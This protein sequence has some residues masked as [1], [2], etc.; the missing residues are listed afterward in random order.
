MRK[1]WNGGHSQR[2]LSVPL[3][4][5]NI[6][7]QTCFP[8]LR[9]ISTS[10]LVSNIIV[11]RTDLFFLSLF[12]S[13]RDNTLC[14]Q[15][16]GPLNIFLILSIDLWIVSQIGCI[17]TTTCVHPIRLFLRVLSFL[18]MP[19]SRSVSHERSRERLGN[20]ASAVMPAVKFSRFLREEKDGN[21]G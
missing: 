6:I 7:F 1:E 8:I 2:R 9:G 19:A 20:R 10:Q 12:L 21:Y 4:S 11:S 17:T 5:D 14:A 16:S 15:I 13:P 3:S 18:E